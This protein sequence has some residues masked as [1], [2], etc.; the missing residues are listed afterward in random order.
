MQNEDANLDQILRILDVGTSYNLL[1]HVVI[2]KFDA[3]F[4]NP[5][6]KLSNAYVHDY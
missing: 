3:T 4:L 6:D 5:A 1:I 2:M